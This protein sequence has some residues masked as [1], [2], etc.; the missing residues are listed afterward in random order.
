MRASGA[1]GLR[2]SPVSRVSAVMATAA[3]LAVA[4]PFVAAARADQTL[5]SPAPSGGTT[6]TVPKNDVVF[7]IGTATRGKGDGRPNLTLEV[8]PGATVTENV[9]VYNLGRTKARLY[10]YAVDA[11][12]SEDG[13]FTIDLPTDEQTTVGKWTS[14]DSRPFTLAG[15]KSRVFPVTIT[16]PAG[17]TPGD[18]V[19]AVVVSSVPR[20]PTLNDPQQAVSVATRVGV[21]T[22]VRVAGQVTPGLELSGFTSTYEPNLGSPGFG[23]L[24][25]NWTVTNTGNVRLGARRHLEVSGAVGGTA[26][27]RDLA[28]IEQVLPGDAIAESLTLEDVF[29]GIRLDSA[30]TMVPV[31]LENDVAAPPAQTGESSV[32]AVHWVL[33]A[34][35]FLLVG[36]LVLFLARLLGRRRRSMG[37]H[38]A[39]PRAAASAVSA[40]SEVSS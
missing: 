31:A 15:G 16:V 21:R 38:A 26:A 32:G 36:M 9:I 4:S 30:L 7:A 10:M 39:G 12:T 28:D 22:L 3:L 2:V 40:N 11:Q 14:I 18:D 33:V 5:P 19:G 8:K 25:L 35:V 20:V 23:T 13:S 27:S 17:T 1:I 6:L 34:V 29:A 24:T 37:R